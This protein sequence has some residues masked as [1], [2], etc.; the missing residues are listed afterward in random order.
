MS[1]QELPVRAA[2]GPGLRCR[3][4]RQE[5][6]LRMLENN[7]ELAE[8]PEDLVVYAGRAKA[9]RDWESYRVLVAA[10]RRLESS[11]TLVVQSG[12]PVGVWETGGRGPLVVMANGNLTG[13]ATQEEAWQL[14]DAGLT[15]WPGMTA[16]AWQYIGSQGIVQGT[17]ETFAAVGRRHFG[18]SLA[19][20]TVLTGGCGGMGGAQPLAGVLAGASILVA[21]VRRDRLE[22]R[23]ATGFLETVTDS[24]PEAL[25]RWREAAARGKPTSIGL[26][27]NVV[28]VLEHLLASGFTPD[29]VTD[30]TTTDPRDGYC[31]AGMT[32]AAVD[33]LRR[34]D[35]D[36]LVARAR[37][38]LAR[39][40]RALLDL[41]DRG[42]IVFEY[43]NWLRREAA[44]AGVSDALT[45]ASFVVEYIRPLFCEGV[46]PFRW[47]AVQ[48]DPAAIATIDELAA[49]LFADDP[50][51]VAWL[52]KATRIP[53]QGL[54]AR[55]CWLGHGQRAALAGAV[56]ALVAAGRIPGPVA[57]TRDHLD[58]ASASIPERETE[59]MHDGSDKISD[60]A[61]LDA[62]LT[63]AAGADLVALHGLAGR[64]QSAGVTVIADGSAPAAERLTRVLDADT[65]LGVL[66]Y[67]DAGYALARDAARR[68]GLGMAA[69]LATD[70]PEAP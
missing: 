61:L 14:M 15:I 16:A 49:D 66:R 55:I 3:G 30:Q 12:K 21:E 57:F 63:G 51:V 70:R 26:V 52:E 9:A 67:A 24:L 64:S 13:G 39:H 68:H 46:G 19:G 48:G 69:W 53:Q 29:V 45:L 50:R 17:Y 38:T 7:L 4:W 18:G 33:E 25:A 2:R 37:E 10:L 34:H 23:L 20:R 44:R 60:W 59:A 22:R 5:T 54:P 62:L 11:E 35:P 36:Q 47:I 28:E 6:L 1:Q 31:P 42:A 8:R 56:N 27:A 43:G 65:G 58:A 41:R 40:G 32:P